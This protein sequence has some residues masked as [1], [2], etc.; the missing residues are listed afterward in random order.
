ME[1][2]IPNLLTLGNLF[3]GFLGILFCLEGDSNLA[4]GGMMVFAGATFDVFDG[5]SARM[6]KV[7]NPIGGELDSLADVVTFGLLPSVIVYKLLALSQV[8][9]MYLFYTDDIPVLALISF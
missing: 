4:W 5:M 6:L 9:W 1:K 3:C 8:D 7:N 2:H